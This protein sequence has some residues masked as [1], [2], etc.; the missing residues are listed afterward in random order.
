MSFDRYGKLIF[1][2]G[3]KQMEEDK[4]AIEVKEIHSKIQKNIQRTIKKKIEKEFKVLSI[5]AVD[6]KSSILFSTFN[7]LS[8]ELLVS[9]FMSLL[10]K[11][12]NLRMRFINEL[13]KLKKEEE[14]NQILND[15][16]NYSGNDDVIKFVKFFNS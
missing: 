10:R 9:A 7:N 1:K 13:F 12:I 4:L 6:D 15:P 14:K 2:K 16:L 3:I 11:N 5:L 8:D